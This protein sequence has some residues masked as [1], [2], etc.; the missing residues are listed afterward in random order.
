MHLFY[1]SIII[2]LLVAY[3]SQV[4]DNWMAY[5]EVKDLRETI[6]RDSYRIMKLCYKEERK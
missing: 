2:G 1:N 3:I 4:Q 6:A 5:A